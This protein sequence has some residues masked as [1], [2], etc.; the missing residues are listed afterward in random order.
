MVTEHRED[1]GAILPNPLSIA[2]T[3]RDGWDHGNPC[4]LWEN[5][6]K[7]FSSLARNGIRRWTAEQAGWALGRGKPIRLIVQNGQF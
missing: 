5:Q 7:A 1:R 3:S 6:G 2:S 4:V